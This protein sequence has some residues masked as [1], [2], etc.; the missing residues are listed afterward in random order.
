LNLQENLCSK[1][2]GLWHP[3]HFPISLGLIGICLLWGWLLAGLV[4][5]G[6]VEEDVGA[7]LA[8]LG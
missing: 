4:V 3:Q 1:V 7:G 8:V 5:G 6:L 2:Y